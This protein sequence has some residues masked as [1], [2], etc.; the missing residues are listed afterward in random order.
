MSALW[1]APGSLMSGDECYLL[2][3]GRAAAASIPVEVGHG[4]HRLREWLRRHRKRST[5]ARR[6]LSRE[7]HRSRAPEALWLR[8][9]ARL[10]QSARR[11]VCDSMRGFRFQ[12]VAIDREGNASP[13]ACLLASRYLDAASDSFS[14]EGLAAFLDGYQETQELEI[15]EIWALKPAL[16]ASIL[17]RLSNAAESR[18][19]RLIASLRQIGETRWV[20]LLENVSIVEK[21]LRSDP[22][23]VYPNMEPES[24]DMYRRSVAQLASCSD[25]TEREVAETAIDLTRTE[26]AFERSG[27]AAEK[28]R[29]VGFYLLDQGLYELRLRVG[30]RLPWS[31][32]LRNRLR[33]NA[34]WFFVLGICI[35]TLVT[36]GILLGNRL[37]MEAIPIG[38]LLL[39]PATQV[40][41]DF[42]NNLV[43]FFF[44]PRQL[45]KLDA[46]K[47]IPAEYTTLVAVP[48]LLLR[49]SQVCD[50]VLDLEIR[51][52]ANRDDNLYFALLTDLPDSDRKSD[53]QGGL[54]DLCRS[55]IEGLNLR[56]EPDGRRPFLLLHRDRSF[57]EREGRW[58]GW[59]R[60]R[61]KLMDLNRL[62]LGYS[63]NF[64]VKIGDLS[65]LPRIRYVI[66]LDSDTQLPRDSAGKLVGT[67]AHPL[68]RPI[69][70][71][72]TRMVVEGHG[73]LQPR[74]G[75]NILSASRSRLASLYSGEKGFDIYTRAVSNAYQDLCGAGI[76]T[77][78]GI[79]E[80]RVLYEVLDH[81]FPE[82]SLLSH[83]LIEGEHARAGLV[84]DIELIDDFPSHFSSY[85]R[86]KHRW[87]RGDWQLMRW[88]LPCVPNFHGKLID[89]PLTAMSRW[90]ILDNL[91]RSLLEPATLLL[92]LAGWFFLPGRALFWTAV[93]LAMLLSPAYTNLLF[94]L[95]GVPFS[96]TGF[97]PWLVKTARELARGHAIA[98]L[99]IALLLTQS[100]LSIDAFGRSMLRLFVTRRKLL[101]WETATEA[102]SSDRRT[103]ALDQYLRCTPA[104]ALA[105]GMALRVAHPVALPV[106]IP[107]LAAWVASWLVVHWLNRTPRLPAYGH[108]EKN[109]E[110]LEDIAER[111][112]RFFRDWSHESTNWLIP[113]SVH[114]DGAMAMRLSP[115]NLGF[116]LNA[117]VAAVRLG[118]LSIAEFA[119]ETT[120]TLETVRKLEKYRGHLMNWYD[121]ETLSALAP[122][123]VSTVDSGN[124][125]A[126][127]WATK[128]AAL[129]FAEGFAVAPGTASRLRTVAETCQ[130]LVTGMDFRFLYN[131][132]RKV[133]RVGFD[134]ERRQLEES[135]YSLL[136]SES[137]AATFVAIAKGDIPQEAWFHL[138]RRQA[139]AYGH[140]ALMSWT[141]TMF[142]YLMPCL[143]MRHF[144]GTIL[145][146]ST[147]SAVRIQQQYGRSKGVPWGVSESCCVG[148]AREYGYRAFGVPALALKPRDD[149][150]LVVAPYATMLA[151][152]IDTRG[153]LDNLRRMKEFDWFGRYGFYEA[154]D[155][156]GAGAHV[157]RSWMAH[158]QGMTLLAACNLLADQA[159]VNYFHAEPAVKATEL[160]LNERLPGGLAVDITEMHPD[161]VFSLEYVA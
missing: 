69:V 17:E 74:I 117:K 65:V 116:L 157:I 42:M 83:D 86:R 94:S 90:K 147:E 9:N 26:A 104:F 85:C 23:G 91:R 149:D 79:Y 48:T 122:R 150:A 76:Y 77:G 97:R 118:M 5:S 44:P 47:G 52:L 106:A 38:L 110:L 136:A 92:L 115:T 56:Y 131:E 135:G 67:L 113:D 159:I 82:N 119:D 16:Y 24:R 21:L 137:R 132:N 107:V 55:L 36:V 96:K 72:V 160:L 59:E 22:E 7:F 63:D 80:V 8:E 154:V 4:S 98:V 93:S 49:E 19:P 51:Y 114:E 20:D 39:L 62:L 140:R 2:A 102:E 130:Q 43:C 111:A 105:I 125:A 1:N 101:E 100:L 31:E 35:V 73:I 127:L 148:E 40:A 61:G 120:K 103:S 28:R 32:R 25:C 71:P 112:W 123:V 108:R 144:P 37:G 58:M 99:N 75:V 155:Y 46:R 3:Q 64:S 139:L 53:E 70:D 27:R 95:L 81:R 142:E 41:V 60:K 11:E 161:T 156:T 34:P 15:G 33:G 14:S 129:H 30:C 88:L 153:A 57:N 50:L 13:R 78:K 18:W 109:A 126:C 84:S 54:V 68:N 87:A 124:L 158:H 143:W 89:N 45:P 152:L 128:Q 6:N 141:G 12:P 29:H 66:A 151:A 121:V 134:V 138:D 146:E 145:Q 133:L 10:I